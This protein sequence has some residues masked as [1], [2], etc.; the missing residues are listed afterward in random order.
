MLRE[1]ESLGFG[2]IAAQNKQH[3][4]LVFRKTPFSDL[5]DECQTKLKRAKIS[6]D[7]YSQTFRPS[8]ATGQSETVQS[9]GDKE[10]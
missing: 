8:P 6:Q 9:T 2:D 5:S 10:E 3:K 4:I 1:A 7:T